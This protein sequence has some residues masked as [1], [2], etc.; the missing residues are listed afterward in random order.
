MLNSAAYAMSHFPSHVIN[1]SELPERGQARRFVSGRLDIFVVYRHE[2]DRRS[3]KRM[4]ARSLPCRHR[5]SRHESTH[6]LRIGRFTTWECYL[7]ANISPLPWNK[8]VFY[9]ASA[10]SLGKYIPMLFYLNGQIQRYR[11]SLSGL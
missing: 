5:G 9:D 8:H 3:N 11:E 7:W 10:R 2:N 4:L 1:V 6:W